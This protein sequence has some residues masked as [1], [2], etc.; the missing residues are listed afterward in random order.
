MPD[1]TEATPTHEPERN[2]WVVR[3]E[4]ELAHLDYSVAGGVMTIHHTIV[5]EPLGGR[6]IAGSLV[7]AALD[8]ARAGGL[9]VRPDCPYAASW[10]DKHPDY[11]DL[12]A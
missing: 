2:R 4:G 5:P 6:G 11:G 1:R 8:H 12:R 3:L 7:R 9:K 10:M